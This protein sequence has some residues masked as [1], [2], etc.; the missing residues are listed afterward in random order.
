MGL[1]N[2]SLVFILNGRFRQDLLYWQ[3]FIFIFQGLCAQTFY[4]HMHTVNYSTF[5]VKVSYI[6]L[7]F[8]SPRFFKKAKGILLSPLSVRF[9]ISS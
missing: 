5:N 6:V 1:E 8:L 2:Q 3:N 4:G 7:L 9:A